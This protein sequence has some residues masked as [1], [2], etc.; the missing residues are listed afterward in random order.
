MRDILGDFS[1]IF[2]GVIIG[3]AIVIFI[4]ALLN[5]IGGCIVRRSRI[6]GG[7][8]MLITSIPII[9]ISTFGSWQY[10][11]AFTGFFLLTG[12]MSFTAAILA[13]IPY[14]NRYKELYVQRKQQKEE[15]NI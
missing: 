13:F 2:G 9:S 1:G 6:A 5:L 4:I 7:V 11:P 12:L 10:A 14:S 8:L 15:N 3:I